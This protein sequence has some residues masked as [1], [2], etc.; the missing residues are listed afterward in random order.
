MYLDTDIILAIIKEK[1][2]LKEFVDASK[3]KD[4]KTSTF[5]IIEAEIILARE[6]ERKDI[7]SMSE[8]LKKPNIKILS[9]DEKI[10]TKSIDLLKE[11]PKLTIFDSVHAAFAFALKEKLMSTDSIFDTIH[12]I[13]KIDPRELHRN[14]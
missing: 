9:F 8:K 7:F 3:I 13:E 12:G 11:H 5:T 14:L 1:D 4:P 2:W 6:Y 10:L